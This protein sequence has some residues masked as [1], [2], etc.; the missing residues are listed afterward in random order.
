M[1][2]CPQC[3][4]NYDDQI[5]VCPADRSQLISVGP[6]ADPMLGRLLGGRYRLVGKVGDGQTGSLYRA[7]DTEMG[8]SCTIKLYTAPSTGTEDAIV[9]FQREAKMAFRIN[10]NHT[11]NIY[12]FGRADDRNVFLVMELLEGE[13]LSQ[14]IAK[15]GVLPL[16]R[17][18]RITTQIAEAL[19]AAHTLGIVHRDLT[20]DN[21]MI[22]RKGANTDFVKVLDFGI[23]KMAA[24]DGG[25]SLT[26][27]GSSLGTPYM[28]PEQLLGEELDPRSDIYSLAMIVYEMLGGRLPFD[29][30]NPQAVMMKR[31][32]SDP[33]PLRAVAP[34]LSEQ[35]ERAVMAGL[36]R[37]PNYRP[38]TVEAFASQLGRVL[39]IDTQI[40]GGVV[41]GSLPRPSETAQRQ[42]SQTQDDVRYARTAPQEPPCPMTRTDS[43]PTPMAPPQMSPSIM[44]EP[45]LAP[46]R[47]AHPPESEPI[48]TTNGLTVTVWYGT[49]RKSH[50]QRNGT[51][52]YSSD[53]DSRVHVGSCRVYVPESHKIGSLGSPWWKRLLTWKDDRLK[54]SKTI[55]LDTNT[56]WEQI[57]RA[58]E[59]I[60]EEDRR[61][62]IYIH[63]FNVSFVDAA[64]RAAQLK[65]DLGITGIVGF[66]SWPSKG[67]VL[68]Y[69]ADAASIEASED[70]IADFLADFAIQCGTALIHVIAHSMGNRGLLR[71]M[72]RILGQ[73]A[74]VSNVSFGQI[75]L[76]APDVDT[77]LFLK[78]AHCY[79]KVSRR[80]TLYV[81]DKDIALQ[82]SGILHDFPRAGF[83]PPVT[84][85]PGIDTVEVSNVD[86]TMLGHGFFANARDVLQDMHNLIMND[87]P[88]EKRMG[89]KKNSP[90]ENGVYWSFK[91]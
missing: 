27:M 30:D 41:R 44:P 46:S 54:V 17:V 35:L 19:S 7:V 81:S 28:S 13:N 60:G 39:N 40:E 36:E 90:D 79:P 76:A 84:I 50:L 73:A 10:N 72:H 55:E 45:S 57:K 66:Y 53:R 34:Y 74:K 37:N 1:K 70:F 31:V 91:S 77:E 4:T 68:G 21:V 62:L 47:A 61:A 89:L 80:T 87:A 29:G 2:I 23:T 86:L 16:E 26:T 75:F 65:C 64:L 32:T 42:S 83:A 15:Q 67:T 3:G 51:V 11:V 59:K 20:P 18:I 63:G 52:S 82:S 69:E 48:Q 25:E 14:I 24:D 43:Y 8:R 6:S 49:N 5:E 71:A 56:Y 88:P 38:P 9:R 78:L 12:D 85:I 22:T 33:I 58:F